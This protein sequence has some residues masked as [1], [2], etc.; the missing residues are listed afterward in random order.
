[1]GSGQEANELVW[2]DATP[3]GFCA[4]DYHY[5]NFDG[6]DLCSPICAS[7][8]FEPAFLKSSRLFC[9]CESLEQP[10]CIYLI[11]IYDWLYFRKIPHKALNQGG[12]LRR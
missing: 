6:G 5:W 2:L 3:R 10:K 7:A 1:M 8:D 12:K 4:A 9:L 11:R